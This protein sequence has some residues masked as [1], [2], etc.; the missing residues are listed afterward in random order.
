MVLFNFEEPALH[1]VDRG[2]HGGLHNI[3]HKMLMN[4]RFLHWIIDRSEPEGLH[5]FL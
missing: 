2:E 4:C 3:L 1:S 5:M